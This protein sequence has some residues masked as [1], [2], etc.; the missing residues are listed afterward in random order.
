[1]TKLKGLCLTTIGLCLMASHASARVVDVPEI[2]GGS[3]ILAT[4]LVLGAVGLIRE[5]K[6][7]K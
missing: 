7:K 4:A 3:A 6:S 5:I 2:D 1:M